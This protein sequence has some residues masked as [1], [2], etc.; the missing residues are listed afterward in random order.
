M[1]NK[2]L[3]EK[4]AATIVINVHIRKES[5]PLMEVSIFSSR[6][7]NKTRNKLQTVRKAFKSNKLNGF[8]AKNH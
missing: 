6:V 7:I 2:I 4:R 8:L 5:Y 1:K 3:K